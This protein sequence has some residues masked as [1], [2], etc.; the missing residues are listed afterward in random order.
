MTAPALETFYGAIQCAVLKSAAICP[1]RCRRVIE[2]RSWLS[3]GIITADERVGENTACIR[4]GSVVIFAD[5]MGVERG[6]DRYVLYEEIVV[7]IREDGSV[8]RGPLWDHHFE[9]REGD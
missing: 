5:I 6:Q 1:V 4:I 7:V 8:E 3:F 2:K 9:P